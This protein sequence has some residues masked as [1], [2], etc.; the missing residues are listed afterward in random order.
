MSAKL[1]RNKNGIP[2][3]VTPR[4]GRRCTNGRTGHEKLVFYLRASAERWVAENV[5]EPE[6]RA[7][8]EPYECDE[9]HWH[10]ATRRNT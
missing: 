4:A 1:A 9:G 6:R 5:H 10:L 2:V 3:E 8:F 7:L